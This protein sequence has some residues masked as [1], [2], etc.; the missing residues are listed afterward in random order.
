MPNRRAQVLGIHAMGGS[1]GAEVLGPVTAGFLLGYF[2]WQTSLQILII[3][4]VLMGIVFIPIAKRIGTSTQKK[5]SALDFKNLLKRWS[6]FEGGQLVMLM[7]SYNMAMMAILAMTPL[8]MQTKHTLDAF[9]TSLIFASMLLIGTIFQP[10]IGKISDRVGRKLIILGCL[11]I[12]AV[13]SLFAG[14]SSSLLFF[15]VTIFI[16]VLALTAVRP[17]VLAAAVEFSA[18]SE[19]TTLG[20]VFATLDGVGAV[21][22]LCAGFIG[23]ID[24][25]YVYFLVATFATASAVLCVW[26][27]FT[28][29][30]RSGSAIA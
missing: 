8:F 30:A 26:F 24:L 11:L 25:S 2:D 18:G 22:A 14:L 16:S 28:P 5:M 3:P 4:A 23:E 7:I 19:A 10:F 1:I 12:A 27:G 17:V 29:S 21:G 15:V 13:F 6:T 20:I 9:T